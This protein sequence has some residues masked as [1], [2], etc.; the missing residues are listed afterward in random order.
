MALFTQTKP[1]APA[2]APPAAPNLIGE[3]E[4]A[5][6]AADAHYARV[7]YESQ[8]Q[9]N[10]RALRDARERA[11]DLHV[12]LTQARERAAALAPTEHPG[13]RSQREADQLRLSRLARDLRTLGV[14]VAPQPWENE[15]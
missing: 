4:A 15:Q 9:P 13:I 3:L 7:A 2:A 1:S 12:Q 5:V 10:E 8:Q 6:E 11:Q 14:A